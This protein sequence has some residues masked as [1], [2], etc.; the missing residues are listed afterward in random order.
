MPVV[1]IVRVAGLLSIPLVL[2]S[3]LGFLKILGFRF[4]AWKTQALFWTTGLANVI[5]IILFTQ[6]WPSYYILMMIGGAVISL[7]GLYVYG[8]LAKMRVG[9][10]SQD[11]VPVQVSYTSLGLFKAYA[12][13][14]LGVVIVMLTRV[15][16]VSE[17]LDHFQFGVSAWGY[18]RISINIFTTAG[19]Y[20]FVTALA[21]YPFRSKN[22]HAGKDFVVASKRSVR[23][24]STLLVGSAAVYLMVDS[25][26]IAQLGKI[27]A[28]GG[29]FV[30][31]SLLSA[32]RIS[33]W[34][35]VRAGTAGG[36]SIFADAGFDCAHTGDTTHGAGRNYSGRDDG[37]TER[38]EAHADCVQRI[39]RKREG[40]RRRNFPHLPAVGDVATCGDRDPFGYPC[41]LVEIGMGKAGWEF[42]DEW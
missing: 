39:A 41:V 5:A 42:C 36:F 33:R 40:A 22:A 18:N 2:L 17:W 20:I 10:T 38:L 28:G 37:A 19:F 12:P 4:F 29:T 16:S 30:Y 11:A 26:Q 7:A 25:G 31:S 13:L 15:R 14:L 1:D 23:S 34:D 8:R 21:C 32:G 3:L 24:L 6:I 35:G 27:L 9:E